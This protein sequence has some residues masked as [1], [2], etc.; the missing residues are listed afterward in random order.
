MVAPARFVIRHQGSLRSVC[1]CV[2]FSCMS[3]F[4]YVCDNCVVEMLEIR[5][6]VGSQNVCIGELY[7]CHIV[8][9]E[10]LMKMCTSEQKGITQHTTTNIGSFMRA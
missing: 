2:C 3:H 9:K 6:C 4:K 8:Q 7:W 10:N 5:L 1:A